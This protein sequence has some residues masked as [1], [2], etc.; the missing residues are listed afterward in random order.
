M[1][2]MCLAAFSI[3][4]AAA[5]MRLELR[6][7]MMVPSSSCIATTTTFVYLGFRSRFISA[8]SLA[9]ITTGL[10]S[11][12]SPMSSMSSFCL[13]SMSELILPFLKSHSAIMYLLIISWQAA[14]LQIS[15]SMMPKPALLTPMSVGD[16]YSASSPVIFSMILLTTGNTS[17]SLL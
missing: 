16:L 13:S 3:A 5:T 8:Y 17:R 4:A 2:L 10:S 6:P 12:L 1:P 14:S 11:T 15:S 7:V 9:G